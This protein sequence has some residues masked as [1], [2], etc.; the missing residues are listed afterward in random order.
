VGELLSSTREWVARGQLFSLSQLLLPAGNSVALC[1]RCFSEKLTT[2]L[3]RYGRDSG[4]IRLRVSQLSCRASPT[5]PIHRSALH[6]P[7]SG[8]K[9]V[10]HRQ[11][12]GTSNRRSHVTHEAHEDRQR[13]AGAHHVR[14]EEVAKPMR[15]ACTI[16]SGGGDAGKGSASR[17]G[18]RLLTH[19]PRLFVSLQGLRKGLPMLPVGE[20]AEGSRKPSFCVDNGVFWDAARLPRPS[21]VAKWVFALLT[22]DGRSDQVKTAIDP[23]RETGPHSDLVLR[24]ESILLSGREFPIEPRCTV[25]APH[26]RCVTPQHLPIPAPGQTIA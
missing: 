21:W 9:G 18:V 12:G 20:L 7:L 5:Y 4:Y 1:G 11:K 13:E 26:R 23:T 22:P 6:R 24:I 15:L 2:A 3:R 19:S 25:R 8:I 17:L 16:W 10:L 14:A